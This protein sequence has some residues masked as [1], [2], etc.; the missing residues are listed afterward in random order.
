MPRH[1]IKRYTP[2]PA[3]LKKHKYLRHLGTWLH[4]ENLWHLNRRSVSG[5]VAAGLFWA[6]IPVPVQMVTSALSAIVFRVN[7]PISVALVWITNPLTMAPVF[8]F[9]YLVGTWLIGAPAHVGAFQPSFEWIMAELN[10]IWKPLFIGSIV[11]G[12]LLGLLGYG[13]MRLYWRWHVLRR[14]RARPR[15]RPKTES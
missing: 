12:T 7:L 10:A 13:A 5:G 2:T 1:L 11:L 14:F 6:M 8:Y 3:A 4:D 9:N 15:R